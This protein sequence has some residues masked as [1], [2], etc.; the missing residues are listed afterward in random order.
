VAGG[1]LD[2]GVDLQMVLRCL[3]VITSRCSGLIHLLPRLHRI[4]QSGPD[5]SESFL[6]LSAPK[7]FYLLLFVV[8]LTFKLAT[9]QEVLV[10]VELELHL[11]RVERL[12]EFLVVASHQLLR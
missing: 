2:A 6:L 12:L 7:L 10:L 8:G 1:A 5:A 9:I 11:L 4:I 3:M